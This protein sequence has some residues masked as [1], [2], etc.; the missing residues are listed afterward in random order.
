MDAV[1]SRLT[2]YTRCSQ[3]SGAFC[4]RPSESRA[5]GEF[6]IGG[7]GSVLVIV[8]PGFMIADVGSPLSSP[9]IRMSSSL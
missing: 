2:S 8:E 3:L 9:G 4:T 1:K 5:R 7:I 6:P